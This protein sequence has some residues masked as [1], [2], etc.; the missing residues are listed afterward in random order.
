MTGDLRLGL[1]LGHWST[2]HDATETVRLAERLGYESVWTS[3]SYGSDALTPLAWYGA[4]TT[5]IGL[6][7]LVQVGARTPAA[8]AMAA[9]TLDRLSRGRLSLGL[10]VSNPQVIEGWYGTDFRHPLAKTREQAGLIRQI[11]RRDA[12][13][14]HP[15]P[16][17]PLPCRGG[18][19]LGKA[20][21]LEVR[22]LRPRIPIYLAASG[23]ANSALAAEVGDGWLAML[24]HPERSG[25]AHPAAMA[26]AGP[27]FD[28]AA[29]VTV[30]ITNDVPAALQKIRATLAVYLGGFGARDLNFH[31]NSIGRLGYR[32]EAE[33]VRD[34]F[35]AGDRTAAAQ[36]VPEDLAD[37]VALVGPIDRI[38]KR[39]Q[40]WRDSPVTTL[41]VTGVRGEPGLRA[42]R[43]AVMG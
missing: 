27:D 14:E 13:L 19:G 24:F 33:R 34:L 29:L 26:R 35:L 1:N 28:I 23:P 9:M 8:V 5:T 10:G 25:P 32:E 36:S 37:A 6:G 21:V 17:Y 15:G 11:L 30:D 41:L 16:H 3:E 18:T 12:P 40:L 39:L 22:P 7:A 38:R 42:I 4:A 20:I 43:D 2:P 31:L